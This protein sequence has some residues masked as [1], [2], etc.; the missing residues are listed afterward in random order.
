[1]FR[2][3]RRH[4]IFRCFECKKNYKKDFNKELI[5]RFEDTYKFCNEDINN[6]FL[7]LRKGVY[8]HENIDNWE[9]FDETSL[10]D[11]NAFHSNPNIKDITDVDCRHAKEYLKN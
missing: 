8:P 2:H 9:R 6:F 1:M 4:L 3:L 10:S 5:K 11:K 7:L